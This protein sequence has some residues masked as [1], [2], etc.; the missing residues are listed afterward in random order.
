MEW[1]KTHM[2]DPLRNNIRARLK[3][4]GQNAKTASVEAGLSATYVRDNL[5]EMVKSP[6]FKKLSAWQTGLAAQQR[7]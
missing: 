1:D 3:K 6:G 5:E 4:L 2:P 7:S